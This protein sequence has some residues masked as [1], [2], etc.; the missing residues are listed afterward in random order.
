MGFRGR[1]EKRR[2]EER[3]ELLEEEVKTGNKEFAL[4]VGKYERLQGLMKRRE[5]NE[6]AKRE[7]IRY[8]HQEI[9]KMDLIFRM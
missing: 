5:M 9:D 3:V 4:L 6:N 8:E 1:E 2:L 7:L